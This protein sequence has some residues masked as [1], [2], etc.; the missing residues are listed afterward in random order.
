M[1]DQH[2]AKH[3]LGCSYLLEGL[4]EDRCPEC[5]RPFDPDDLNTFRLGGPPG[6]G[7]LVVAL[8]AALLA[9]VRPLLLELEDWDVLTRP[10]SATT[11]STID[12]I[13]QVL[14]LF[15]L[16]VAMALIV[17]VSHGLM[18]HSGDLEARKFLRAALAVSMMTVAGWIGW[19]VVAM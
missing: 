5:G 14:S 17:G 15:G 13:S 4:S 10:T 16:G 19:F 11:G 8:I 3:C 1:M 2:R 6:K 9:F 18:V 12:A 7:Y